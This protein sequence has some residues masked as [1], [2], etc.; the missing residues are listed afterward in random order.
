MRPPPRPRLEAQP[1]SCRQAR[2]LGREALGRRRAPPRRVRGAGA[3]TA[4]ARARARRPRLG[5]GSGARGGGRREGPAEVRELHGGR[6]GG[7]PGDRRREDRLAART[8]L[9]APAFPARCRERTGGRRCGGSARG[10]QAGWAGARV[11]EGRWRFR[12]CR[13]EALGAAGAR[14]PAPGGLPAAAPEAGCGRSFPL[15]SHGATLG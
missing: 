5:P 3:C 6:L 13:A 12:G 15:L 7:P 10:S 4:R 9:R 14:R 8:C 1:S 11:P 2:G